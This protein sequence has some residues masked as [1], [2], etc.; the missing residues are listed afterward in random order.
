M[1]LALLSAQQL[2]PLLPCFDLNQLTFVSV[3]CSWTPSKRKL[4][5]CLWSFSYVLSAAYDSFNSHD[6]LVKQV[7]LKLREVR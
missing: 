6:K 7:P 1:Q 3:T 5:T 4:E 2:F